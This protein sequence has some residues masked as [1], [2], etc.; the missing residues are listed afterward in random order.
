VLQGPVSI[1]ELRGKMS[2]VC[3]DVV[4]YLHVYDIKIVAQSPFKNEV[5]ALIVDL[6]GLAKET[7]FGAMP[8][9]MRNREEVSI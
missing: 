1:H 2:H 8:C 5:L 4:G 6:A 3:S 7:Y 9:K